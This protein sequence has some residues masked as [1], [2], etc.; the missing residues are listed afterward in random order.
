MS[1]GAGVDRKIMKDEGELKLI[2]F[3]LNG[4]NMTK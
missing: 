4:Q 3:R 1:E 2:F